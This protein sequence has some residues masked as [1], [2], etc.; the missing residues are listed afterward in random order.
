MNTESEES[1]KFRDK[2]SFADKILD[3]YAKET[4]DGFAVNLCL[5]LS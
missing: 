3:V 2:T 1:T 4:S 5:K